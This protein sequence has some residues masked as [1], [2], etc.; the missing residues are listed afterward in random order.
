MLRL[1]P[2]V[3]RSPLNCLF[4]NFLCPL[5]HHFASCSSLSSSLV[6]LFLTLSSWSPSSLVVPYI[7]HLVLPLSQA[8]SLYIPVSTVFSHQQVPLS[9]CPSPLNYLCIRALTLPLFLSVSSHSPCPDALPLAI[10]R[11]LHPSPSL[12]PRGALE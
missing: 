3:T 1:N 9:L 7:M 8:P 5:I 12:T 6:S 2:Q 11:P 4:F 10:H